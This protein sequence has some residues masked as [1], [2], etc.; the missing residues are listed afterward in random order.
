M[1]NRHKGKKV[2]AERGE[3]KMYRVSLGPRGRTEPLPPRAAGRGPSC[4][5]LALV[6][7]LAGHFCCRPAGKLGARSCAGL[8]AQTHG[9]GPPAS[10]Q[11]WACRP[12]EDPEGSRPARP[13]EASLRVQGS[14]DEH[15]GDGGA[16]GPCRRLGRNHS[17]WE[18][19][20]GKQSWKDVAGGTNSWCS[21]GGEASKSHKKFIQRRKSQLSIKE[22][23]TFQ[24]TMRNQTH[25]TYYLC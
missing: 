22:G 9:L 18:W 20:G 4:A 24:K 1:F 5:W 19:G 12:A 13:S 21:R 15:D 7:H 17:C 10:A 8:E 2:G 3:E 16:L 14:W 6:R 11:V 23:C 25:R